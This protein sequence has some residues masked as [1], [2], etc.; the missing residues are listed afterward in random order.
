MHLRMVQALYGICVF[1]AATI[2][3]MSWTV[4]RVASLKSTLYHTPVAFRWV[5]CIALHYITLYY[6]T[7]RYVTLLYITLHYI[8]LHYITSRSNG[9]ARRRWRRRRLAAQYGAARAG[10]VTPVRSFARFVTEQ[11]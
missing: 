1:G 6:T 11:Y 2:C 10:D 9:C 8:T 3:Y 7:L 5:L 4:A